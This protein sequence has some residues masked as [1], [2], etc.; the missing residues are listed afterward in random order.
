MLHGSRVN[1]S[2]NRSRLSSTAT[3]IFPPV[4]VFL[5]GGFSPEGVQPRWK[6]ALGCFIPHL[7]PT[8]FLGFLL[9]WKVQVTP[10]SRR[11]C[12]T[13]RDGGRI[14]GGWGVG[15]GRFSQPLHWSVC[16]GSRTC[17][18]PLWRL[19]YSISFASILSNNRHCQKLSNI[20]ANNL[21]NL[22]EY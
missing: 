11:P 15:E 13:W 12:C 8:P 10:N 2:I 9:R 1:M 19:Y 22:K 3:P 17:G 16:D 5:P 4:P 14:D 20:K 21:E 18:H 6:G 7:F